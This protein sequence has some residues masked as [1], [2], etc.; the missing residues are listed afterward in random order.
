MSKKSTWIVFLRI[1][2]ITA[3]IVAYL[4]R[5][6]LAELP[7]L[8]I[9]FMGF[10]WGIVTLLAF[11]ARIYWI[12]SS[13]FTQFNVYRRQ[14][15]YYLFHEEIGAREHSA[16]V[17]IVANII[18]LLFFPIGAIVLDYF[19][20]DKNIFVKINAT[21][22]AIF[23]F[24]CEAIWCGLFRSI[25]TIVKERANTK[26]DL[27]AGMKTGPYVAS[28]AVVDFFICILESAIFTYGFY[29]LVNN[30]EY[31]DMGV[32]AY[33]GI[34]LTMKFPKVGVVFT[35]KL[36]EFTPYLE[37]GITF[38]FVL[39]A[40]NALGIMISCLSKTEVKASTFAPYIIL[41]QLVLS[42]VMF[43]LSGIV[44]KASNYIISRI[45]T[46]TIGAILN[47]KSYAIEEGFDPD[48]L[49]LCFDYTKE[50]VIQAWILLAIIALIEIVIGNIF[51]KSAVKDR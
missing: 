3:I 19:I 30:R 38:L 22:I 37:I 42:G 49:K 4:S 47:L 32:A 45:G 23:I 31:E 50:H 40:S 41:M 44:D 1:I 24:I 33:T 21:E 51:L 15:V 14:Y 35:D 25:L 9:V 17:T 20:I 48:A 7:K 18:K 39:F 12:G 29:L 13:L 28:R 2:C 43:D 10:I 36:G 5:S 6:Y 46:E 11:T 16:F 27:I 8:L 26:R 34:P